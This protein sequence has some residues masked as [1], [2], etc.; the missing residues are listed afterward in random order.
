MAPDLTGIIKDPWVVRHVS[1]T[2]QTIDTQYRYEG[3]CVC[4]FVCVCVY[5]YV[6]VCEN[7]K[8]KQ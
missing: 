8:E 5:V 7:E 1:Q 3:V 6:C 2:I 4:M